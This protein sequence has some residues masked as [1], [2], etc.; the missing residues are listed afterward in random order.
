M[1]D[2]ND[3]AKAAVESYDSWLD[4]NDTGD[5]RA[6]EALEKFMEEV[7]L[8]PQPKTV[9][10][11]VEWAN[12][13]WVPSNCDAIAYNPA[14]GKLHYYKYS[15]GINDKWFHCCFREEFE[16]YVEG[17]EQVD[18][19]I[20]IDKMKSQYNKEKQEGEKWTHKWN[21]RKCIVVFT[22]DYMSWV[23][24]EGL[25][26]LV[27]TD[28]LKPIKPTISEDAKRQ[29]ELYVQYRVDKYGDYSM[30]SDLSDYLSHHEII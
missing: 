15:E 21:G 14:S 25:N 1:I 26:K 19:D 16:A 8:K 23:K 24:G 29:L 22:D 11:A 18:L 12:R 13:K 6:C 30:K 17:V 2:W 7:V 9:A 4:C 28:S 5:M 10:D 20:D 27:P 3:N